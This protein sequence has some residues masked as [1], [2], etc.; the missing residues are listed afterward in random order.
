M[1]IGFGWY[2][3]KLSHLDWLLPLLP[4]DAHHYVEPFGGSMAVLLNKKPSPM[5]TYN[6]LDGD[7]VNFFRV[8]R[9]REEELQRKLSLTF[10]SR[11]EY[12]N[13]L[14]RDPE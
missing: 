12:E 6:D 11:Q 9:N 4:T 13:A 2:G 3:G 8:L 5:E 1:K 14:I 10:Y 7:L